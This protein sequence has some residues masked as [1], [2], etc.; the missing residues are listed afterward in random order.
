MT[1]NLKDVL[2]LIVRA[3]DGD[4][5]TAHDL[6]FD[7]QQWTT[8]YVVGDTTGHW[9]GGRKVLLPMSV[10]TGE[11]DWERKRIAVRLSSDQVKQ[12][13]QMDLAKPVSRLEEERLAAEYRWPAYWTAPS[14]EVWS[15]PGVQ[16]QAGIA[17][18]GRPARERDREPLAAEDDSRLRS[19]VEVLKYNLQ[20]LDG[21]THRIAGLLA[22]EGTWRIAYLVLEVGTLLRPETILVPSRAV[23][24]IDWRLSAVHSSLR[25]A[26]IEKSPDFEPKLPLTPELEQQYEQ[27]YRQFS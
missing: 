18:T 24:S 21:T 16:A 9:P 2:G 14:A 15:P 19:V 5:G 10:V 20:S 4:I 11:P 26:D 17:G 3:S 25:G 8:R 7:D 22:H 1:F 27:Y 12:S 6:Y 23:T 13:P